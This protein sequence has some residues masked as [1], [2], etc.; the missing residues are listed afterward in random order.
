MNDH[1]DFDDHVEFI[2]MRFNYIG[3]KEEER[4]KVGEGEE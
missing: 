4:G 3:E 1:D 2:L